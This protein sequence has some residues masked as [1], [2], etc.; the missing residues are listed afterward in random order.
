MH[1][2]LFVFFN[3]ESICLVQ[4]WIYITQ[5]PFELDAE[6]L[7]VESQESKDLGKE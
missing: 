1:I 7:F 5:P 3:I 4:I 6:T 2:C